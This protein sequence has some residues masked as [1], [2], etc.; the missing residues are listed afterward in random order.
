MTYEITVAVVLKDG[1]WKKEEIVYTASDNE[2]NELYPYAATITD[3]LLHKA[4]D[5]CKLHNL[6]GEEVLGYA[7]LS[8]KLA[9]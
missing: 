5:T 9:L 7:V 8:I 2:L 1:S 4:L 6:G 3:K